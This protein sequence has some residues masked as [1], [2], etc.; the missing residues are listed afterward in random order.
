MLRDSHVLG[1]QSSK[2]TSNLTPVNF[3]AS[4]ELAFGHYNAPKFERF[5]W[6]KILRLVY[7]DEVEINVHL[8]TQSTVQKWRE[9]YLLCPPSSSCFWE[10]S[11]E[12]NWLSWS[13]TAKAAIQAYHWSSFISHRWSS[14]HY[15]IQNLESLNLKT[16][17]EPW[18]KT[19]SIKS[20]LVSLFHPPISE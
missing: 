14:K 5:R 11:S 19:E 3:F 15:E 10:L 20:D 18:N 1:I 4:W 17:S 13:P 9:N 12:K 7:Y 6:P 2:S 8:L 16:G